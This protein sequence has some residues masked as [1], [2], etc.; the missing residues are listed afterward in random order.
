[1]R[2]ET[3]ISIL[4]CYRIIKPVYILELF[5]GLAN[6]AVVMLDKCVIYIKLIS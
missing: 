6:F 5:T 2:I 3:Q 4:A 1:M